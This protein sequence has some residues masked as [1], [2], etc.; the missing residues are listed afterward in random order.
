M[1]A[2]MPALGECP[3]TCEACGRRL[4][5]KGHHGALF[6]FLFGDVPV[7]VRCLFVCLYQ[8][9]GNVKSVATLEFGGDAVAPEL[10]Y[11]AGQRRVSAPINAIRR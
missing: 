7:R 2:Q 11:A 9:E 10:A 1:S 8:D 6:R 5:A 3:R 4:A